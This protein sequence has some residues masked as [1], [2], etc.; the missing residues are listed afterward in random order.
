MAKMCA[1]GQFYSQTVQDTMIQL[2][3]KLPVIFLGTNSNETRGSVDYP[4]L[5]RLRNVLMRSDC[6]L[7]KHLYP[8]HLKFG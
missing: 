8:K 5:L 1:P 4:R 2:K 7:F 6:K 3:I